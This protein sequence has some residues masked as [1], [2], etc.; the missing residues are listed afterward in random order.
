LPLTDVSSATLHPGCR[1][2]S[3]IDKPK[4]REIVKRHYQ[5]KEQKLRERILKKAEQDEKLSREMEESE[6]EKR[7][8]F[9]FRLADESLPASEC[10]ANEYVAKKELPSTYEK[11]DYPVNESELMEFKRQLNEKSLDVIKRDKLHAK[12][13]VNNAND[14]NKEIGISCGQKIGNRVIIRS[15]HDRICSEPRG[16]SNYYHLRGTGELST[17]LTHEQWLDSL[18]NDPEILVSTNEC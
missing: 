13:A 17:C 10:D 14:G 11:F 7:E 1:I 8:N 18:A 15:F 2:V 12:L 9:V 6:R 3:T 5:H 4:N 16:E